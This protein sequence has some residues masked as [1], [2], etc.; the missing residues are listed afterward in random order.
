L[1][2]VGSRPPTAKPSQTDD[3]LN[4][5][6]N[7]IGTRHTDFR[8][9][10]ATDGTTIA[11]TALRINPQLRGARLV[12][13][14]DNI[15]FGLPSQG[16]LLFVEDDVLVRMSLADQLRRAGY[17]VLEAS[18]ADEALHILE[19]YGVRLVLSDVRLPGTLDGV[20]L[21]HVVR[22]RYPEIKIVLASGQSFSAPQWTDIDGFFPKP[23][24]AGRLID[25][26]KRLLG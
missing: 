26:I 24:D 2:L 14:R 20:E 6:S 10:I 16:T 23:Y 3:E 19:S 5:A 25:H 18:S 12:P 15:P 1:G 22:A 4:L 21:A 8:L 9:E 13:A 7:T 11:T 17:G